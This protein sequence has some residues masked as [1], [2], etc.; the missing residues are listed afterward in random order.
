M[1]IPGEGPFIGQAISDQ[2]GPNELSCRILIVDDDAPLRRTLPHV[3]AQPGRSFEECGSVAE[4][5]A[6]LESQSFDLI[7]LDYRLPDATG[8]ALLDWLQ[9]RHREEAVVMISGEDAIDAAIG[10]LRRGADDFVRKPYHVAQLQRAV[11]SA[12]HKAALE[13]ANRAMSNRLRASERLHRYLVESSPDLIFTLDP[14]TRFTYINPRIETLLGYERHQLLNRPFACILLP[15]DVDRLELLLNTPENAP[16]SGYNVELRLCRNRAAWP[17][18]ASELITVAL[19]AVP[20]YS[21]PD[22]ESGTRHL[23]T[24]GVARD[25]SE[26]KRAEEIISFQ[27]YHDQ[28]TRLPNRILFK[29]RLE[30]A[31]AQAQRR[32]GSLGVMFVDV[33]RFKLV[34]DTYGHADGDILLRGLA[35]R[36]RDTLRRGD[37]LARL[38]GDEF[39]VIL[40]DINQP[41]DVETIA[42]KILDALQQPFTL[43]HGDFRITASI[44]ISIFPRDGDTA[45]LLLQHAD[46]AM[47]QIKRSGRNG[48]RFFDSDLNAH[49]R[50]RIELENDLRTALER[51]EFELY[52]QPQVSYAERRVVGVEALLRW[53]HPMHGLLSP[54]SFV[55][56]AEEVGLISGISR[57]VIDQASR[58][59]AKWRKAG[60]TSL[61]MSLNLSPHDIEREDI[62]EI[63]SSTLRTN[64]VPPEFLDLEIT[65]SVMMEDT[66]SVT[67]KIKQLR[68]TGVGISIDD[69]GT[70]YSALA[71]LQRFPVSCLKIDRSFVNDLSSPGTHPIVSAITGIARGFGLNLVAEGVETS[72]QAQVLRKLGCDCMQVYYF[73]RPKSCTDVEEL[74]DALPDHLFA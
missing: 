58:Q 51:G 68:A 13:R 9:S 46:V 55:Q 10:A 2:S 27:A 5:V 54:A 44:G 35:A 62:V 32:S 30:L 17:K 7:L 25:I 31:I 50:Q 65:E 72:A 69:F 63:V 56:V 16:A 26:R 18:S 20:M 41:E 24:Y 66:D 49:Y 36:L 74:L 14:L 48:F 67:A 40:P 23:G 59:L 52:Y 38:G 39:T 12:L 8:L 42:R 29:D 43:S 64:E 33:D 19:N 73:S 57:W 45:E 60:R 21:R 37:T 47:Y 28:L 53:H 61:R 71:Y 22:A 70:G 1:V 4:A 11:Q 15:E 34:N 6:R 3:L